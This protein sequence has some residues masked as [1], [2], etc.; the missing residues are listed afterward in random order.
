[1]SP[2][3][4]PPRALVIGATGFIG[5]WLVLEL[6][7]RG[8]PVAATFRGTTAGAALR[9]WLRTHGGDERGLTTVAADVTAPG[10][11]LRP[12]GEDRLG[13]V[14]DVYNLAARYQFGLTRAEAEPVN[15]HGALNALRWSATLPG[16]R[17][18]VHLSG[19]RTGR[20]PR[21]RYP[22]DA[23][24]ADALYSTDGAYPASKRLG[25]AAVRVTAPELGVPVTTVNP[26]NVIGHSQTG[27]YGQRFGLAAVVRQLQ[28]GQLPVL[29]G[30]KRTFV[31][32]V[33]VDHLAAFLAA[34]PALDE[35]PVQSHT[36]LDPATPYFPELVEKL[37]AHLGV[38][39]PRAMIPVGLVRHLPRG[40]TGASPEAL[41]FL[42]EDRYD[43]ASAERLAAAA[44]LTHPPVVPALQRWAGRLVAEA[45]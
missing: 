35:G 37:A 43:T 39:P 12:G 40:I 31:P 33:T 7:G 16:L 42:S 20:D 15:V 5:R 26:S 6:L 45:P 44:G 23:Q 11:G 4:P 14:R 17:R 8:T 3:P 1:M 29:P 34:V 41:T 30:S 18:H 22:L 24:A 25:D 19:Y 10:L 27:E 9:R 21:P 38:R 28:A 32:V 36:V 2:T 13:E